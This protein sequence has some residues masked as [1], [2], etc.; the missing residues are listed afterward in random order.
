MGVGKVRSLDW[1]LKVADQVFKAYGER[2]KQGAR[3]E[4]SLKDY[5]LVH[6]SGQYGTRSLVQDYAASVVMTSAKLKDSD[7]RA[8]LV[9]NFLLATWS[10][11]TLG[12]FVDAL[13]YIAEPAGIYCLELPLGAGWR[14]VDSWIDL[15]KALYVV[16]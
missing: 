8:G 15:R 3:S 1:L 5:L 10:P 4:Q 12:A 9:H 7:P 16:D 6:F 2:L 13:Q 11:S 14:S